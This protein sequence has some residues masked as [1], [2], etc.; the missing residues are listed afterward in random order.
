MAAI[1]YCSF[2]S[3]SAL[4]CNFLSCFPAPSRLLLSLKPIWASCL[5]LVRARDSMSALLPCLLEAVTRKGAP[6]AADP[7]GGRAAA[8]LTLLSVRLSSCEFS[9]CLPLLPLLPPPAITAHEWE[10]LRAILSTLACCLHLGDLASSRGSRG[11]EAGAREERRV[12]GKKEEAQE[13]AV[14]EE[15]N[16]VTRRT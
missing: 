7:S 12:S 9:A 11:R 16:E 10:S 1:T 13:E 4:D 5:V 6:H 14:E 2:A 8:T 3:A 15:V